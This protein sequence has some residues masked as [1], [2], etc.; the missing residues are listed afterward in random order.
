MAFLQKNFGLIGDAG[1]S[2]VPR[3]WAYKTDDAHAVVDTVG[4]FDAVS[5]L[6]RVGD[7]IDV[8][9]VSNLNL[10]T[11][12]AGTYGRHQVDTVTAAGVVDVTD[13]TVGTVT[14][15]D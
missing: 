7:L 9:V 13:V 12:A 1:N 8:V 4:Y 3:L 14:D 11:E 2:D 5:G 10:S 6:V 15:T